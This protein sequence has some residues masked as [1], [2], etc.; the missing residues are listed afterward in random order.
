MKWIS[1]T[2]SYLTIFQKMQFC[3]GGYLLFNAFMHAVF[4]VLLTHL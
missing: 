1:H 2:K 4:D 3:Y